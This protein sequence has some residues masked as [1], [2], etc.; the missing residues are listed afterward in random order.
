MANLSAF[1]GAQPIT[2]GGLVEL[3]YGQTTSNTL[4]NNATAGTGT[5]VIA[6]VTVVCDGSP[7]LVE[8]FSPEARPSTTAN[9]EMNI[10]LFEDSSEKIRSWGRNYNGAGGFN[11]KPAY[12]SVRLTPSAGS[13]TY[14]VK[15]YVTDAARAGSVGGGTGTSTTS[16]PCFLRV[17]KIVQQ[18]DGLKPFWT[19][20]LVTQ[21]P[22]NPTVGDTVMYAADATNGVYWNLYYD[23]LGSYP[24]KYVG[25]PP[26]YDE[27]GSYQAITSASYVDLT[28]VTLNT[29]L[30]GDYDVRLD[31][32]LVQPNVGT[33]AIYLSVS[34]AGGTLGDYTYPIAYAPST[35]G[36]DYGGS[37]MARI[38][39]LTANNTLQGRAR[40][41]QGTGYVGFCRLIATPVRVAA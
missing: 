34:H 32:Q 30:A 31:A 18:N 29:T 3:G 26:L 6:P 39:G 23:G 7:I 27:G 24:W 25:G 21:L 4:I 37:R 20:P 11:N 19:P 14:G 1:G 15:A 13:H 36:I 12:L 5:E 35:G 28:G 16:A 38:L 10:S 8:F 40:V 33:G 9:D 17:S 41:N 2:P 22:T